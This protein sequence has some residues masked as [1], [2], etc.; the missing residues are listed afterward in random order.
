MI[1]MIAAVGKNYELG[2]GNDLIWHLPD[3]MKFFKGA[4]KGHTVI[5]GRKTFLSL[6]GLLPGRHHVVL[7]RDDT[8]EHDGVEVLHST[9]DV[10]KKYGDS[11]EENFVIGGGEIYRAFLPYADT[12]YLTHIDGVCGDAEVFFPR[13]DESLYDISVISEIENDGIKAKIIKYCRNHKI[14]QLHETK[15]DRK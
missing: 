7:T 8:F 3:D 10:L 2:K 14:Q 12:V 6:P 11:S 9:D 5:M 13:F 4:T 1:S 15:A